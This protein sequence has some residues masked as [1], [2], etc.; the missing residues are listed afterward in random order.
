MDHST[1]ARPRE[2]RNRPWP[3]ATR[4]A[5][6]ADIE[7]GVLYS[8]ISAKYGVSAGNVSKVAISL[9]LRRLNRNGTVPETRRAE[10]AARRRAEMRTSL[11]SAESG[12]AR[13]FGTHRNSK[14]LWHDAFDILTPEAAYWCGF[15]FTDGT[16]VRRPDRAPTVAL[17][18][19]K[20]DRGHLEKLRD[21]LASAHAIT[22]VHPAKVS[23]RYAAPNG[24][25]GTGAVRFA[26]TS[27]RIADRLE[28]LGRYGPAV[29]PGLAASRDFWRGVID[30]DGTVGVSCGIPHVK[31]WG[32]RWLLRSFVEFLGP[33]SRH[34]LNARPARS[35]YVVST[36]YRTAEKLVDRLYAG[37]GVALDR[38][39]EKAAG[40]L[41]TRDAPV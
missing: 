32:T 7:A 3:K 30:G 27:R 15:L 11:A 34:P 13:G 26:V 10:V 6:I 2:P 22:E 14:P 40:I 31:L 36:S 23:P 21:F 38:K 17:V 24:G 9:G 35:I 33:I 5:I 25:R 39:A 12:T 41:A 8:E 20:G 37:A 4:D 29:N 18:I 1:P 19:Q 28:A 16:I